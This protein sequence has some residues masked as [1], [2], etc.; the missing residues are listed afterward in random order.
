[1][2]ILKYFIITDFFNECKLDNLSQSFLST[3]ETTSTSIEKIGM[4][5]EP[6]P[7]GKKLVYELFFSSLKPLPSDRNY[8]NET[9]KSKL[10]SN[11]FK[12]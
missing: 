6:C 2:D 1:M 9:Q 3:I 12:C 8:G 4:R 7:N 11:K 10:N 5:V